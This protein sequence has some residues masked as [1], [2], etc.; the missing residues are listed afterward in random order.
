[1]WRSRCTASRCRIKVAQ[2]L[3]GSFAAKEDKVSEQDEKIAATLAAGMLA[4]H[5]A[6]RWTGQ[7]RKDVKYAVGL[8]EMFLEEVMSLRPGGDL[9]SE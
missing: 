2:V 9:P 5:G 4:S 1:M 6:G 7:L 8:Y 3:T